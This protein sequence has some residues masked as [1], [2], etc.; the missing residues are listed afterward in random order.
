MQ[1]DRKLGAVIKGHRPA[2]KRFSPVRVSQDDAIRFAELGV[3]GEIAALLA[4]VG[5]LSFAQIRQRLVYPVETIELAIRHQPTWFAVGSGRVFV[6]EVYL[7]Q[8]RKA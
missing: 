1:R 7:E 5:P 8:A 2:A 6:T 4:R 3:C